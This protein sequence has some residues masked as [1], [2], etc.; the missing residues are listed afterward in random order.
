LQQASVSLLW[1]ILQL[2]RHMIRRR[3]LN[4]TI[5]L[6]SMDPGQNWKGRIFSG[7]C[8]LVRV[9]AGVAR[10][11]PHLAEGS[12]WSVLSQPWKLRKR[13]ATT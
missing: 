8:C 10:V 13:S 5:Q 3:G 11:I 9:H 1:W 12:T 6:G 4:P 2:L 7:V